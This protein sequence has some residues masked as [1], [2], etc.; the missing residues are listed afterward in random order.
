MSKS[1]GFGSIS[2]NTTTGSLPRCVLRNMICHAMLGAKCGSQKGSK[3][4]RVLDAHHAVICSR[5][6]KGRSAI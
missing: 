3:C 6:H 2:D 1:N 5:D 4:A